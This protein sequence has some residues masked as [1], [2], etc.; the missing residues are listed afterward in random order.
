[1]SVNWLAHAISGASF[2]GRLIDELSDHRNRYARFIILVDKLGHLQQRPGDPLGQHK[3]CE[4]RA[5]I[6]R[7]VAAKGKIDADGVSPADSEA[8]QRPHTR[9]DEIAEHP[10]GKSQ[11]RN[12]GSEHIPMMSLA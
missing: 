11:F 7:I 4:K 5:D 1:M 6:D 10:F 12:T 9:L 2:F 3:E 8:L